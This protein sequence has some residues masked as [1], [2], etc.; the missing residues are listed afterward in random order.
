MRPE[1]EL[2]QALTV[3]PLVEVSGPF[4]RVAK[5]AYV[6]EPLRRRRTLGALDAMGSKLVGGRFNVKGRFEVLYL[7]GD[8][9]TAQLEAEVVLFGTGLTAGRQAAPTVHVGV[10]GKVVRALDLTNSE[11]LQALGTSVEEIRATWRVIQATGGEAPTQLLGRL[12]R[13]SRRVE[14]M[15]YWSAKNVG[16]GRCLAVFPDRIAP[17]SELLVADDSGQLKPERLPRGRVRRK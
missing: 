3:L 11:V 7:A 1:P 10:D 4:H 8:A 15:V 17:P 9:V 5:L 2:R 12:A 14:G 13:Q 16:G 6:L